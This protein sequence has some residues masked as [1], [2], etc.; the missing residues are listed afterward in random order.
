MSTVHDS[1]RD[2]TRLAPDAAGGGGSGRPSDAAI[3]SVRAHLGRRSIVIVGLMGCGKTSVG[4]RLAQRLA[5]PFVDA[6]EEIE[7]AAGRSIP[8]IFADYGEAYFRDGERRVIG[9]LLAAGPQVLA[10]GGG[11]FM[12]AETR[13]RVAER[14]VSVWLKAELEV[15]LRRVL[16]RDNRPLLKAQDPKAVMRRLM[17]ERYPVYALADII[18]ESRDVSHEVV[19]GE[20]IQALAAHGWPPPPSPPETSTP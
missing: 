13:A 1:P 7:R 15:L 4:R 18:I 9:R 11:A 3:A 5:I 12:N 8:D 6:D 19:A 2:H 16:R 14:G 17:A 20:I 10:T